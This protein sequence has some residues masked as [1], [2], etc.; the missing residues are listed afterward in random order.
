MVGANVIIKHTYRYQGHAT[1]LV[2][3][4]LNLTWERQSPGL[5]TRTG[6]RAP[7]REPSHPLARTSA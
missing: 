5:A 6:F 1:S 4:K 7:E 2:P 3:D